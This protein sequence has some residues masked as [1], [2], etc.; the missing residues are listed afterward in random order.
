[1][2]KEAR[3]YNKKRTAKLLMLI[4][5]IC[6]CAALNLFFNEHLQGDDILAS[7]VIL[8]WSGIFSSVGA[9][10]VW[11]LHQYGE[12][13]TTSKKTNIAEGKKVY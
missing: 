12:L 11:T 7:L 2:F 1:M 5:L 4:S 8:L 6:L 3:K 9:F 10:Y 13:S